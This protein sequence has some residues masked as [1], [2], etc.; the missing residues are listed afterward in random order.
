MVDYYHIFSLGMTLEQQQN[1]ELTFFPARAT[2]KKTTA[3]NPAAEKSSLCPAK[4]K[5]STRDRGDSTAT[6]DI[7]YRRL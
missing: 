3:T 5:P 4:N 2:K 7:V 6:T 1:T